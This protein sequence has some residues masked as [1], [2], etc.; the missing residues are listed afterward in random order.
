MKKRVE[1][2]E[3]GLPSEKQPNAS[4]RD[5]ESS[6]R[7]ESFQAMG[8]LWR[9]EF[10]SSCRLCAVYAVAS[11]IRQFASADPRGPPR[12]PRDET[13]SWGRLIESGLLAVPAGTELLESQEIHA[14][15]QLLAVFPCG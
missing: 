5:V 6:T 3:K 7:L 9:V 14:P 4:S 1:P 2:L 12:G 8:L 15:K 11:I 10:A 13:L